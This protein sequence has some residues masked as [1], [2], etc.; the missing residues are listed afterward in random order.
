MTWLWEKNWKKV[1]QD[2]RKE[3]CKVIHLTMYGLPFQ[4]EV[5]KLRQEQNLLVV[6][7]SEKVPR[8][9]Y[10]LADFNLAVTSQPHSET[11][12]LSVF[13]HELFAGKELGAK[14]SNAKNVIIP[15]KHGKKVVKGV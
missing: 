5:S 3:G 1:I 6:I 4:E 7:G 13:L 2:A 15:Q 9:M 11:S 12:A 8:E 14:F 10:E